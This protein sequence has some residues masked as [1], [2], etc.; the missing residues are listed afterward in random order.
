M[1][2]RAAGMRSVE[3]ADLTRATNRGRVRILRVRYRGGAE[4]V[5]GLAGGPVRASSGRSGGVRARSCYEAGSPS[6]APRAW[7]RRTTRP[8]MPAGETTTPRPKPGRVVQRPDNS[9][10]VRA[11][12]RNRGGPL[13]L[14]SHRGHRDRRFSGGLFPILWLRATDAEGRSIVQFGSTFHGCGLSASQGERTGSG[15]GAKRRCYVAANRTGVRHRNGRGPR[16]TVLG[17]LNKRAILTEPAGVFAKWVQVD[18]S[19]GG[20]N[21]KTVAVRPLTIA[22]ELLSSGP[23]ATWLVV[24]PAPIVA[25]LVQ[26]GSVEG[27]LMLFEMLLVPSANAA[28]GS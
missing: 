24:N 14:A 22:K 15:Y 8:T 26:V 9:K 28:G 12:H 11:D 7:R 18:I 17:Q 21:W 1:G 5:C 13:Q 3:Q 10:S 2:P 16:G 6:E 25:A 20:T 4:G 23:Q 19:P 27:L